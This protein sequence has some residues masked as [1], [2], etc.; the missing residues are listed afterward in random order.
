MRI[1]VVDDD[2]SSRRMLRRLIE[3]KTSFQIVGEAEDGAEALAAVEELR[4]DVVVMDVEM[5]RV[6]GIQATRNIKRMHPNIRVLAFTSA[7]GEQVVNAMYEAG[8][9][10]FV[11]KPETDELL[12]ELRGPKTSGLKASRKKL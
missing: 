7:G 12:Y 6:D 9:A 2:S 8:A 1:L 11:L 10:G 3:R 5:P 4:P